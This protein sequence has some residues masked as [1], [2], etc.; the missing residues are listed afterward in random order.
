MR[1]SIKTP[2]CIDYAGGK[3]PYET[4]IA[5]RFGSVKKKIQEKMHITAVTFV[6]LKQYIVA[7][8]IDPSKGI[9][10]E[11][12]VRCGIIREFS[13]GVRLLTNGMEDF[14]YV[15]DI[16]V[17]EA[18]TSAIEK[19]K[20]L[21]GK[22]TLV[23]YNKDLLDYYRNPSNFFFKPPQTFPTTIK[24][25]RLYSDPR[26]GGFLADAF[27][28]DDA[29]EDCIAKLRMLQESKQEEIS[30]KLLSLPSG[31]RHLGKKGKI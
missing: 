24:H 8:I 5:P 14:D 20:A 18:T 9:N 25:F 21:G 2:I 17:N 1:H 27:S 19:I 15:L 23:Y 11:T 29:L 6:T 10:L 31:Y 16:E 22:I 28:K 7:G 12:F 26:R 30:E 3:P 4:C 13:H